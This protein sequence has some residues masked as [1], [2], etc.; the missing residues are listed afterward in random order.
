[1]P[2]SGRRAVAPNR[3]SNAIS[4]SRAQ[5][6]GAKT[7]ADLFL[8]EYGNVGGDPGVAEIPAALDNG[9]FDLVGIDTVVVFAVETA[10]QIT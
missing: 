1:M 7:V 9:S 6:E 8:H 5:S 2:I 10:T 4:A 3:C